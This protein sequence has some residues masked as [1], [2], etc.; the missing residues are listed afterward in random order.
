MS[1]GSVT[2]PEG[3][4]R[5]RPRTGEGRSVSTHEHPR[6]GIAPLGLGRWP[7]VPAV[8][9][10]P[11]PDRATGRPVPVTD[12]AAAERAVARGLADGDPAALEAA[13][14]SWGRLVH[15]YCRRVAGR[16]AADDLTQQVFVE[17]WRTRDRFD[18]E[19]GA[20]PAW[21]VGIAR[22]L[23]ARHWR[24]QARTPTP[25]AAVED[26]E[27]TTDDVDP[28]LLA[29]RLVVTA[30]LDV[31]SEPQRATL[32]LAFYEDLTQ[33]EIAERLDLPLGTVKSHHRRGLARLRDHLE[34]SHVPR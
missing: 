24:Q 30:A 13:F 28:D 14:R 16:G 21:L 22:N 12:G 23:A 7:T 34:T 33:A 8:A 27:P 9:D 26:A 4:V 29:D 25:V 18:P 31:L 20:V 6:H 3:R 1:A 19:R 10:D 2:L 17:A 11:A 5:T 15:G 32:H